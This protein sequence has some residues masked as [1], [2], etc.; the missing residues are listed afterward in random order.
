MKAVFKY[1]KKYRYGNGEIANFEIVESL[2]KYKNECRQK[3]L[4]FDFTVKP[5]SCLSREGKIVVRGTGTRSELTIAM[6]KLFVDTLELK[7]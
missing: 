2:E 4:R 6:G 3:G 5:D 7:W 1:E